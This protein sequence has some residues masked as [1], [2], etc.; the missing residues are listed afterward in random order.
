MATSSQND[1]MPRL[2]Y[3]RSKSVIDTTPVSTTSSFGNYSKKKNRPT[4]KRYTIST[5]YNNYKEPNDSKDESK[6]NYFALF[7]KKKQ[8]FISAVSVRYKW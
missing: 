3:T 6:W 4:N 7:Y 2:P 8:T 1:I 5:I